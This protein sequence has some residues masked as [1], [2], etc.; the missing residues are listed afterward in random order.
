MYFNIES[1]NFS[2]D[3]NDSII[4]CPEIDYEK[5]YQNKIK[6]IMQFKIDISFE[7]EF[8]GIK[9][10]CSQQILDYIE[11]TYIS[12]KIP[13]NYKFNISHEQ[14]RYF[15]RLYENLGI[16]YYND[17]IIKTV[18]YKIFKKIYI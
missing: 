13:R 8:I 5:E 9:N 11:N 15:K 7:P 18:I 2:D 10:I 14:I 6:L 16:D 3:E 4:D 12:V 17:N 1:N